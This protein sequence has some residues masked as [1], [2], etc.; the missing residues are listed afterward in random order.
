MMQLLQSRH[1]PVSY[2]L[3]G[4]LVRTC[5][6]WCCT[7]RYAGLF[8]WIHVNRCDSAST[9]CA[10]MACAARR[11]GG[12][13][14]SWL[15]ASCMRACRWASWSARG[16]KQPIE[17]AVGWWV[18][19]GPWVPTLFG[20]AAHTTARSSPTHDA[21]AGGPHMGNDRSLLA[22]VGLLA[23]GVAATCPCGPFPRRRPYTC[24]IVERPILT[25][26]QMGPAHC[27]A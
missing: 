4:D 1:T 24:C 20:A 23:I 14:A 27:A 19:R 21:A 22:S 25:F 16:A 5:G 12:V 10:Y 9:S 15:W 6:P 7:L 11:K 8:V 18:P 3:G 13:A 26:R 17:S 2:D